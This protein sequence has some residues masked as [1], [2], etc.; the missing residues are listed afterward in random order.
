MGA[1]ARAPGGWLTLSE[2]AAPAAEYDILIVVF[3]EAAGGVMVIG[4]T[5]R[6]GT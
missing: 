4:P 1:H 5:G 6:R 2:L 3:L